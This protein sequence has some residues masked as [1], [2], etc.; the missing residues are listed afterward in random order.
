MDLFAGAGGASF[1]YELAG[2]RVSMPLLP[3][4]KPT[5]HTPPQ[6]AAALFCNAGPG[7]GRFRALAHAAS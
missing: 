3:P 6:A 2:A 7:T 1:G 4:A 5:R